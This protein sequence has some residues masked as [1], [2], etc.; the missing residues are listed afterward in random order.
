MRVDAD[1]AAAFARAYDPQG[2]HLDE[3]AGAASVFGGV[4]VSGWFTAALTMRM[5]VDGG[6]PLAGGI[7]GNAVELSWPAPVRPGDVL[8]AESEIVSIE[9]SRSTPGRARA[10]VATT[11]LDEHGTV[12]MRLRST[13]IVTG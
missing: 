13:L 8:H 11:T 10:I 5:L 4:V 3:A 12:V 2:F 6:L 1:E 7:V 9:P